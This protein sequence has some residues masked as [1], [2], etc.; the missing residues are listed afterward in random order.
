MF[1]LVVAGS[2]KTTMSIATGHQEYHP[3][4][5]SPG[6][7]TNVAWWAYGN[8]LL[9][10]AFLPIPKTLENSELQKNCHQMYHACLAHIFEP[11]K[12]GMT[13]PEV[14]KCPDG[15][16]CR[17][18]Y[19]LGLYIADYPEQVWLASIVQGWHPKC[20]T[21]LDHLNQPNSHQCTHEKTNFLIS[22]WIPEH[23][24]PFTH[25]FPSADIHKL[26]TPDLLHQVIKGTFKDHIIIILAVPP[27]L[28]LQQFPDGCDFAQW[29]GD[30][31]KAL[32]K[33]YLAAIAGHVPSE[34]VQCL[35]AFL[36]F[37]YIVWHNAI[38]AEDLV[39]LQSILD[40]FHTHCEVFIGTAGITG[41]RISLPC[42]HSL[43]H[44][45]CCIILFSSPNGLCS[46]ITESK[47]IKAVKEPWQRSSRFKALKQMLLSAASQAH[48][49]LGMMDGTMFLYEQ[50]NLN[51]ATSPEDVLLNE[52][53]SF[54]GKISVFHSAIAHFYAP[55]DLCSA[56]GM[57]CEH[58]YSNPN[59]CREYAHYD[60]MFV[61]TNSE[62]DGMPGMAIGS[63]HL[64]SYSCVLVHWLVPYD[65]PDKDTGIWVVQPEYQ[66]NGHHTLSI[67]SSFLPKDF[68]FAD[69][70]DV[71]LTYFVNPYI[72]H[73]S[74]E[75][76]K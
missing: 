46:S 14:V 8:A 68:H 54:V 67:V 17:A 74:N 32:M 59:W 27:F 38:T 30:D 53:P 21:P 41:E 49:E 19:G 56:G 47:H 75:F 29:T 44:Y 23:Y 20:D 1:V 4:Y 7:L 58:I 55:S 15:H 25:G 37:C 39:E 11:L 45:I 72:D 64:T 71:F 63:A 5:M 9:P 51:S 61:E 6:N 62:L 33:V 48:T 34:M 3:V 66:G 65:E 26:L 43:M 70:L 35:A 50:V 69:S 31:S 73:H 16:F 24:G 13:T 2:D 22:A 28:G 36:D 76:L 10:V 52:C 40:H 18:V 57:Y 12:A 42:Q 60:T